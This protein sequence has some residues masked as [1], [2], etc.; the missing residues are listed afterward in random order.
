MSFHGITI[1]CLYKK[2]CFNFK[3][4]FWTVL[5]LII[6]RCIILNAKDAKDNHLAL[7]HTKNH[8]DL[9]KNISS[10]NSE[11]RRKRIAAKFNSI[12]FNEGSSEAAYLAAGSV[13][14]VWLLRLVIKTCPRLFCWYHLAHTMKKLGKKSLT[15]LGSGK[16]D[17]AISRFWGLLLAPATLQQI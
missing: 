15:F 12:Y 17:V 6:S 16:S 8:I 5:T 1:F 4:F 2:G 10:R 14:E 7:V 11:S 3:K 9:I 13:I